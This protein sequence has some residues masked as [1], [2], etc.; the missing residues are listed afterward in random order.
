MGVRVE[1]SGRN[2]VGSG[3]ATLRTIL[4]HRDLKWEA[5]TDWQAGIIIDSTL[6]PSERNV[7]ELASFFRRSLGR[8][9]CNSRAIF[10]SG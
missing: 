6:L 4:K 10:G 3:L 5:N 8:A 7:H 1:R 9:R 2:G